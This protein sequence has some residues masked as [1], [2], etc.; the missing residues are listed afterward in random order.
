MQIKTK[1]VHKRLHFKQLAGLIDDDQAIELNTDE[2]GNIT[3]HIENMGCDVMQSIV[4]VA[5]VPDDE[6]LNY[7]PSTRETLQAL[8]NG[9]DSVICIKD[10][11]GRYILS[12]EYFA[13][14][15][16]RPQKDILG[17]SDYDLFDEDLANHL[18]EIDEQ[19]FATGEARIYEGH[20]PYID[21][22]LQ[23]YLTNKIPLQNGRGEI[24]AVAVVGTNIAI[25]KEKERALGALRTEQ[26]KLLSSLQQKYN[27]L[28]DEVGKRQKV[29]AQLEA[30]AKSLLGENEA[31]SRFLANMSHEIRTPITSIIGYAEAIEEG[32][33]DASSIETIIRN[34]KHL[35]SVINDILDLSKIEAQKLDVEIIE[36]DFFRLLKDVESVVS[37]TA[38]DKGLEFFFEYQIPLPDRILCDATRLRQI[39]IN[40]CNNAIKFTEKGYIQIWVSN[41]RIHERLFFSVVDTGIGMSEQQQQS[42]FEPFSQADSSTSRLYGGTGLGLNIS[43]SLAHLMGGDITFTSEEHLGSCFTLEIEMNLSKSCKFVYDVPV[44]NL[45]GEVKVVDT[46]LLSGLVL[47]A[48][49]HDDNRKL[50]VMMLKKMGL[51]VVEACN[52]EQAVEKAMTHDFDLI[53]LDIQMPVMDGL[54]ARAMMSQ[55]GVDAPII[56]LTAN[57]MKH[58]VELY[59]EVG[60]D[61]YLAKPIKRGHFIQTIASYLGQNDGVDDAKL[62][63]VEDTFDK[64][65]FGQMKN[66][67]IETLRFEVE[68][69]ANYANGENYQQIARISHMIK[70]TAGSFGLDEASRLATEIEK[71]ARSK[72]IDLLIVEALSGYVA[73]IAQQ[74][75]DYRQ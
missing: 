64:Q 6:V 23:P 52:G 55:V 74:K 35:L 61:D 5:A 47:L 19:I 72:H 11:K 53:L 18:N 29:E 49:D 54:Q 38:T 46:P 30:L 62:G 68:E 24:Y 71:Q 10:A 59:L 26:Q 50:I 28:E 9:I 3:I 16:G 39:L 15:L 12:N 36:I 25:Q 48:E 1:M 17:H 65:A 31:K 4:D 43:R 44:E 40:L 41:D 33:V 69:L 57:A 42:L 7:F 60:F 22:S 66:N 21:G 63:N 37:K 20:Y 58:E 73:E 2:Q 13:K 51:T 45:A 70:G 27:E 8:F 75:V 32:D 34:G 67:Y 14:V 56:A